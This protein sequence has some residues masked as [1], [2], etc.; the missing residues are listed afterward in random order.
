MLALHILSM[1]SESEIL[2]HDTILVD[3]FDAGC[4]EVI[5]EI[6]EGFVLVELGSVKKTPCPC[7]DGRDGVS[8]RFVALLP[9]TVVS[10][11]GTYFPSI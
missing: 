8:G 5:A 7:E 4:L 2:G 6:T 3:D 1:D 11:D 10:G 9:F